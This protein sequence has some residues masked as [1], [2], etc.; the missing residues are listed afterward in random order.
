MSTHDSDRSKGWEEIGYKGR[1]IIAPVSLLGMVS[2]N[3]R[4]GVGSS[5]GPL[6]LVGSWKRRSMRYSVASRHKVGVWEYRSGRIDY[7]SETWSGT[8]GLRD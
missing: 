8:E 3:R 1:K 4:E 5:C 7:T 6:L 2:T